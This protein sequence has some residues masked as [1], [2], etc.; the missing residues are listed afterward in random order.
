MFKR[1]KRISIFIPKE[2]GIVFFLRVVLVYKARKISAEWK[3]IGSDISEATSP[4]KNTGFSPR[5]AH[6]FHKT[7]SGICRSRL[8]SYF[9]SMPGSWYIMKADD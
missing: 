3:G 5:Q 7:G 2:Q 6:S 9:Q 4:K 8:L 1:I